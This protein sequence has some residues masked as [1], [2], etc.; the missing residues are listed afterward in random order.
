M[1]LC[2]RES[3]D[4]GIG[5]GVTVFFFIENVVVKEGEVRFRWVMGVG[6]LFRLKYFLVNY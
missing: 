2:W 4:L 3:I 6:R 5:R 1:G